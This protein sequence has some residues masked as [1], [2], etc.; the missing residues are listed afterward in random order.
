MTSTYSSQPRT[1]KRHRMPCGRCGFPM[2]TDELPQ[3]YVLRD[4][5][6]RRVDFHPLTIRSDGNG[7]QHNRDG[8][9]WTLAPAG[10]QGTGVIGGRPVHCIPPA[11][12]V[13]E[14]MDYEPDETDP[15]T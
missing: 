14:H 3:G 15:M 4:G 11:E 12:Q 2:M 10:F 13:R 7:I 1:S 5:A 9:T 6:D 8:G